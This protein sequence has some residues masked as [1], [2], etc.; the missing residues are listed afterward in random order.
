MYEWLE[1]LHLESPHLIKALLAGLLVSTVCGVV[2]C[3]IVL[4]GSAFLA[5]AVAHAMLAGVVCGY[6]VTKKFF[7][8][9]EQEHSQW[10]A[11]AVLIGSVIAGFITVGLVTFVA[12]YSRVKESAIIGIMYTGVFAVGGLLA[13]LNSADIHIDLLHF[14]TGQVLAVN[15][16]KLWVMAAV[17]GFVIAMVILFFRSL[18][19]ITFDRV[20]AASIGV[21]V[22]A[23]DYLLTTCTSLVVVSGVNVV[24]VILVVGLLI[25]PAATAYLLCDRLWKMIT[26]SAVF[27]WTSFLAGYGMSEY[28]S[29]APGSSIVVAASL[30]FA[31]VFVCAPRY[32]LLTDW[33]RRRRAIP[34]QLVEDV[35]G[36]VLRDERQQVPMET[37]FTYVEGREETI[38][39]AV[40]SLERQDLLSV[41]G[42]LLQLTETGL[43]E[44]R[45][46]LRSHRL[47]ET[48]LEHLGTPGEELH[49]RAHELEHVHDES[50][51]DYLD[52]KLGHPLIDPHG[53]EIPED[54]VDLVP[55]HEVPLAILREG[56]SGEVVKVTDTGL[57]SEL[58]IGTI[59]HVGPRRDQGQTWTIRFSLADEKDAGE[60]E[61]DHDGADAVTVLLH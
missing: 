35:L 14:V 18:Q 53:S 12:H 24:G 37:V 50:A 32:G 22:V 17:T 13:S 27:G 10:F 40:R 43:P 46:L 16:G 41:E 51:V 39:R 56:H 36:S 52:D 42:D 60:L 4:R 59:I 7:G 49:G 28:L 48:Y 11:V 21:P 34:Q 29:V 38:R 33:L 8:L 55:G 15:D 58:P 61:L 23:F 57:A 44:A 31:I 54:F 45:R 1:T 6:L 25:T 26:L 5:D 47:W 3:F 19:L 30:Q 2:G 20:M 9:N